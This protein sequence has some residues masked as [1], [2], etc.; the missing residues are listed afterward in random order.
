MLHNGGRLK[1][2][3]GFF[4]VQGIFPDDTYDAAT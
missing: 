2:L 4:T 3:E 1:Y